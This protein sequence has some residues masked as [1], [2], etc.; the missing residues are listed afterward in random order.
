MRKLFI[1]YSLTG[2][3]QVVADFLNESGYEIRK[4]ETKEPLPSNSFLRLL[5]GGF[6]ALIGYKDKLINFN[7]D[8]SSYKDIIIGSPVWNNRLSSPVLSAI[9]NLNLS[10]KNVTIVLCSASGKYKNVIKNVSKKCKNAKIII[11]KEPKNNVDAS[12]EMLLKNL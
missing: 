3:T 11:L 1:Y 7:N 6:K 4:I 9:S 2:N 12:R 5:V 10:D 8:I